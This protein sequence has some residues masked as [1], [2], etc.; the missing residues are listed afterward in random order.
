[1]AEYDVPAALDKVLEVTKQEKIFLVGQS[2]GATILFS[3]LS[4]NK[5]F[6]DKVGV[7]FDSDPSF[8]NRIINGIFCQIQCTHA[9]ESSSSNRRLK[10]NGSPIG[11]YL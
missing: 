6:D 8:S 11:F 4:E 10:K 1:M 5:R 2:M 7:A 9:V 3:T